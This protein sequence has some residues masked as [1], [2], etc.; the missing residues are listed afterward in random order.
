M[1]GK[2]TKKLAG[3]LLCLTLSFLSFPMDCALALQT[4]PWQGSFDALGKPLP[5]L[6]GREGEELVAFVVSRLRGSKTVPPFPARL[7]ADSDPRIC[8]LTL[9]DGMGKRKAALGRGRGIAQAL[10]A[11]IVSASGEPLSKVFRW[12]KVDLVKGARIV[13]GFDPEKP[14]DFDYSLFGIAIGA[15]PETAFLPEELSLLLGGKGK[16]LSSDRANALLNETRILPKG[17]G[18]DRKASV[19]AVFTTISFFADGE[20]SWPLFRGNRP[21]ESYSQRDVDTALDLAGRYL[22]GTVKPDGSFIYLYDTYRNE[23]QK[24]YNI[25]RHAG[26]V[27]SMLEL[28]QRKKAPLLLSSSERALAFLASFVR[29]GKVS[30]KPVRF[31]LEGNEVKLGGN[32]LA[33]LAFTEYQKAT[34]DKRYEKT[35]LNLGDWILATQDPDGGFSVH[36]QFHPGGKVSS[37][38][39]EYYP[40]EAVFALARLHAIT[41]ERKWLDAAESGALYQLRVFSKLADSA[42]PHDHW[43]LYGLGELYGKRPRREFLE[44]AM[45]F[46]NVIVRAQHTEKNQPYPDWAGGYYV[47]PRSAPTATRIEGLNSAYALAVAGGNRKE[48]EAIRKAIDRGIGYLLRSQ[49]GPETALYCAAPQKSLGAIRESL[50]SPLVRIDYVQHA[51]SALIHRAP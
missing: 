12:V 19:S 33:I 6:Q 38:R 30:G 1:M 36:K 15:D 27:F 25:L 23:Q 42:L 24:G 4:Q 17:P 49:V 39:S 10:E 21:W 45:R 18:I 28:Y 34:G 7:R 37:F 14:F 16:G 11:A 29:E 32:A 9:G 46:A 51:I 35:A 13:K 2:N 43:L 3:L 8:F 48:A 20:K 26:S 31:I 5:D 44:G 47:P 40:G 22:A 41:G 50:N